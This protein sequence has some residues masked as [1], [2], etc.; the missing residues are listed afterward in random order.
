MI[1]CIYVVYLR[2][3]I[4]FWSHFAGLI[5]KKGP[6]ID[7]FDLDKFKCMFV[8]A[9]QFIPDWLQPQGRPFIPG[10]VISQS[11]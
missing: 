2:I 10:Q 3:Y 8:A 11:G 1:N 7:L 6:N 5:Y 9:L 4:R